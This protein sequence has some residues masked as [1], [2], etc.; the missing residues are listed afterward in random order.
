MP[1]FTV[2]VRLPKHAARLREFRTAGLEEQ[3]QGVA[4]NGFRGGPAI[5][6]FGAVVPIGDPVLQVARRNGILGLI[7]QCGLFADLFLGQLAL[8]DLDMHHHRAFA[9][10][11]LQWRRH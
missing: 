1:H 3:F 6:P 9:A 2:P 5:Q 7:E 11:F 4:A 8:R 10:A